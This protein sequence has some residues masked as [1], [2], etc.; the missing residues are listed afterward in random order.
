MSSKEN[1]NEIKEIFFNDEE[2]P[3]YY[4]KK[5]AFGIITHNSTVYHQ[6][7]SWKFNVGMP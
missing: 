2:N 5:L 1:Q 4:K 7:F 6:T 3:V